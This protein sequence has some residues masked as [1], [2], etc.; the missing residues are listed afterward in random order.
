[1]SL[2]RDIAD[3]SSVSARLDTLGASSGQLSNRNILM[4]GAQVI[5]QRGT[6]AI[7]ASASSDTFITDRFRISNYSD[8]TFTGQQVADAPTDF[9]YSCKVTTTGTDTSLAAAQYQRFITAIEGYNMNHLNYGTSNAKTC[10]LTFHVKSSLTGAFYVFG[11][12]AAANRSIVVGYTIDA[13]NTWEKKTLTIAGD[14]SGSW[15]TTNGAGMYFG[16]LLGSGT[17]R[18]TTTTDAFQAGFY[19]GKS[20][21]VNLAGT[22]GATWQITGVQLEVGTATDFEHEPV[23][24]T[25]NKCRRYYNQVLKG[26]WGVASAAG[27]PVFHFFNTVEMRAAPSFSLTVNKVAMGDMI[28]TGFNL[29]GASIAA[30]THNTSQVSVWSFTASS[31]SSTMTNYRPLLLESISGGSFNGEV[32]ISA[33]L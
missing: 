1:M 2:A 33:E 21:Q 9:E 25:L 26:A 19:M 12:N 18:H 16:W 13:A 4:N 27:N 29:D 10:T 22:N 28:T 7:T 31:F 24:V 6:S 8:A 32:Q 20:D 14:T 17:D 5:S 15:N 11:F 3:L 30:G 23:G